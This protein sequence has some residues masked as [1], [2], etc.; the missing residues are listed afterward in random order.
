MIKR[1]AKVSINLLLI[2]V[3]LFSFWRIGEHIDFNKTWRTITSLKI[4]II[5]LIVL[6]T[7]SAYTLRTYRWMLLLNHQRNKTSFTAASVSLMYGYFVNLGIPRLGEIARAGA[8]NKQ[9]K[10][11]FSFV[12]GTIVV[13]RLID[14]LSLASLLLIY[15]L[16]FSKI[17]TTYY[18]ERITSILIEIPKIPFWVI[19]SSMVFIVFIVYWIVKKLPSVIKPHLKSFKKGFTSII[20][21]SNKF[22]FF[23]LTLGIWISYFFTSYL[24]FFSFDHQYHLSII[25]G[26]SV[27]ILGSVVRSIPIQGGS[28]GVFHTAVISILTLSIFGIDEQTAF[29]ISFVIHAIQTLFQLITGSLAAVYLSVIKR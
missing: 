4:D 22:L 13:E 10:K 7:I 12:L 16:V 1:I 21:I 2:T 17:L 20:G 26:I 15:L 25:A 3:G 5:L 14:I 9:T 24:C 18:N 19:T 27:L 6:A 28:L 11:P 8:I 29:T 23:S